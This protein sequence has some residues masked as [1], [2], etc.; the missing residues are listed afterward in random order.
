VVDRT[1]T[2]MSPFDPHMLGDNIGLIEGAADAVVG[3][4]PSSNELAQATERSE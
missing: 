4:C 1:V 2:P 3:S